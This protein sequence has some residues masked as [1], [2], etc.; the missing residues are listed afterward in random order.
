MLQHLAIVSVAAPLF[1]LG[2]VRWT[3]APV[4]AWLL[5]A[6]V[7]WGT[8]LTPFY[9]AA[10]GAVP[11]HV[12]EHFL[13]LGA[14][15]LFWSPVLQPLDRRPNWPWRA[16]YLIA[17]VPQQ[18]FL[19]LILYSFTDV[20]YPSYGSGPEAL[21]EQRTGALIMWLGGDALLLGILAACVF[22]WLRSEAT[23]R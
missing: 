9:D 17:A 10:L 22:V 13:Y 2:G 14:A 18:S 3:I 1:V 16:G 12:F 7:M 20:V 23:I 21:A 19:G 8:H 5:F 4:A 15:L 6:V 11:L